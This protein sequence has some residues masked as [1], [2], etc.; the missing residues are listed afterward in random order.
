[1]KTFRPKVYVYAA[2]AIVVVIAVLLYCFFFTDFS[3]KSTTEYI[4]I[5]ADDTADSVVV[6]LGR[7][8]KPHAVN[9]FSNLARHTGYE[10][11]K[12]RTGR[13]AVEP[14]ES[15]FSLFRKIKNGMQSPVKLTMPESRTTERLAGV[16]AHKLMLDS[17]EVA[18]KLA[19]QDFCSTYGCDTSTVMALFIPDTYEVYWNI[20]LDKLMKKMEKANSNFWNQERTSKAKVM[21]LTKVEVATLAS[22]VDEETANNSEKPMIAGMYYNRLKKGMPLQADPTIKFALKDF[23]LRRIYHKLLT[24]DSPYNTYKNQGLPPGPIKIASVAGIDAVLNYVNHDYLYMCAKEDFSGTHNF[25]VT[26][27]EHLK[28]AAKY[29]KALNNRGIK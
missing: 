27:D 29:T 18:G 24:V 7:V 23:G 9:A 14:G 10:G 5:D 3:K 16:L 8:G 13:Y 1:M 11:D 15:T 21:G 25:A 12:I 19:D 4:Y 20:S 28:N 2:L 22:I 26:Y 6:K 17:A